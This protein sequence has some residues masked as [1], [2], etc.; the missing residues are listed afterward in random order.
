MSLLD[1][2]QL[3]EMF[4]RRGNDLTLLDALNEELER[5]DNEAA[6]DLHIKVVMARR[7][8]MRAQPSAE[9]RRA[10]LRPETLSRLAVCVSPRAGSP[11]VRMDG[12]SI[13]T[14]WKMTNMNRPKRC[15]GA[16][17]A[18]AVWLSR[19]AAPARCSSRIAR[20]GSAV[21][22]PQRS[23]AGT[24]RHPIFFPP[25]LMPANKRYRRRSGL[26]APSATKERRNAS[27]SSPLR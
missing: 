27:F 7:A 25:C 10:A 8:L 19:T 16:W 4:Q 6:N 12:R 5:R 15:C 1:D 9:P 3:A 26:L 17:R 18:L 20:S 24:T 23:F 11:R 2:G 22:R 14:E 21:S 13:A